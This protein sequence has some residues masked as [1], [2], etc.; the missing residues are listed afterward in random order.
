MD[1]G[2]ICGESG[3]ARAL[4]PKEVFED[5]G[6]RERDFLAVYELRGK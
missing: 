2:C 4:V 3:R 6:A 5:A 1:I